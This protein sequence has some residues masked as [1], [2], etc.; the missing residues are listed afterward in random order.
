MLAEVGASGDPMVEEAAAWVGGIA[1]P[2][3]KSLPFVLPTAA[4]Y[5]HAPWMVPS[6][7]GSHLTFAIAGALWDAGSA[8]PWLERASE[9]C[10]AKSSGPTS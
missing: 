9:W 3:G 8:D 2:D 4:D 1:G 6:D 5:P 7:G 10:W